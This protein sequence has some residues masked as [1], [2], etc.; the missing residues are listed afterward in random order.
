M[1]AFAILAM[2][3]SMAEGNLEVGGDAQS[4]TSRLEVVYIHSH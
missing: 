4:N 3:I 2:F 1:T